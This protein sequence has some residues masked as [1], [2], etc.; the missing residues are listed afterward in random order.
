MSN[1]LAPFA[2]AILALASILPAQGWSVT[3]YGPSCGPVASGTVTPQGNTHRFAF[4]V[5]NAAP[6]TPVLLIVGVSETNVPIN[7][8]HSCTL[9][10]ELY[11]TQAHRTDM[12]GSY[13]WSHALASTFRGTGRVQF[14]EVTFGPLGELIVRTSNGV[15]MQWI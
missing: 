7:F 12:S 15:F 1:F 9:L 14:A 11:F 5:T 13:T 8:G 2:A 10:T 3:P 4:T 6:S